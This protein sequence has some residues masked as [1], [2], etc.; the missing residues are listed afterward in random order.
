MY[1][2]I[3]V[4]TDGSKL[5]GKAVSEAVK[6]AATCGAKITLLHVVADF[7]K[8]MSETYAVP[9]ALAAPI[10]KKFQ[11]EA[12]TRSRKIIDTAGAAAAAAS[13]SCAGV[14][15]VSDSPY[16]AIIKQAGKSKCDV[17]VMASHGRRGL[18]G[19]L[20]GSETT[21]VLCHTKI[22]VLVVR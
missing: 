6:L 7:R 19:F 2:H 3:L 8:A 21:K 13:I 15:M 18:Q 11:D 17:I 4:P 1:K 20:L 16:E 14:S 9:A 12:A 5:S 22:P 10:Q